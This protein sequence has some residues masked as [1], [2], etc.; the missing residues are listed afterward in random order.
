MKKKYLIYFLLFSLFITTTTALKAQELIIRNG[1]HWN[2]F[3]Q[4]SLS[5]NWYEHSAKQWNQGNTP[6]GYGDRKNNTTIYFGDDKNNKQITK[7]FSKT[8]VLNEKNMFLAFEIKLQRDDGAVVYVNGKEL[9]RD[10]M[11]EGTI[12]SNTHAI[13]YIDKEEESKF[14]AKI[15]DN[16]TFQ[17]GKNTIAVEVH[18]SSARSS[19]LIF[20]LELIGHNNPEVL[21]EVVNSK[22]KENLVLES[23]IKSLTTDL[24]L[25]KLNSENQTL[26]NNNN[27]LKYILFIV[28]FMLI[29]LLFI[30]VFVYNIIK[31]REQKT[32]KQLQKTILKNETNEKELIQLSTHLLHNKQYFKE[33]KADLKGLKTEDKS[34][35][36]GII[37]QINEILESDKDWENLK[38]HFN[39]INEGFYDKLL[40]KHSGL[41]ETELRHCMFIK[42]HLQTKEIATIL[43]I[44]PRSVQTARYR[45]KKKMDLDE[46][47]DLRDYLLN[48]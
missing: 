37:F 3:D 42:L 5:R 1:D 47:T 21:R 33:I 25:E 28:A 14:I 26:K 40:K 38:N 22:T 29:L 19:D 24:Q 45:I 10:N 48:I 8:F 13:R 36:K 43:L 44:D 31:R 18:Q 34:I 15:F 30:G 32:E 41:T 20:S 11:P 16:K 23:T 35:I 4:G 7:Y 46:N 9:F 12:N 17:K 39:A 2:Y 27:T 6:I